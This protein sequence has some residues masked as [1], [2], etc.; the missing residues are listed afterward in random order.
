[1]G[2]NVELALKKLG[3]FLNSQFPILTIY[4]GAVSKQ[5]PAAKLL[6]SQFH[7]LV[8]QNLSKKEQKIFNQ[9]LKKIE[10]YLRMTYDKRGKKTVIF[11]SS[12]Q[13]LWEILELNFYLPPLCLVSYSPYL[14]PLDGH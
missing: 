14:N 12:G 3:K 13:K 5:A 1:M 7:S 11:F 6:L 10:D 8:H 4:L 2:Q 9:D